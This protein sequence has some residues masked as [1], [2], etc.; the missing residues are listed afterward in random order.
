M[1]IVG[2]IIEE[3]QVAPLEKKVKGLE[4]LLEV[5]KAFHRVAVKERD[6][7]RH[8]YDSVKAAAVD[9]QTALDDANYKLKRIEAIVVGLET[10]E[11]PCALTD[12][13]EHYKEKYARFLGTLFR[14]ILGA[15]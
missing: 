13:E 12:P 5:E 6:Y 8:R 15:K 7:E 11:A 4:A 3:T 14:G 1:S 9:L 10:G 2:D